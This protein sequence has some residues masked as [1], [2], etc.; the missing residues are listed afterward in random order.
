LR[1]H[2]SQLQARNIVQT[3]LSRV[4]VLASPG[5]G[6]THTL[7]R[8]VQWL[9]SKPVPRT[10]ILVLSFSTAAVRELR[11]RMDAASTNVSPSLATQ[12]SGV[13]IKTIHGYALSL[14]PPAPLL[15]QPA[16]KAMLKK[17]I[18][19][20]AR[21]CRR[22]QLWP[23]LGD[24][25]RVRRSDRILELI[26]PLQLVL[27]GRVLAKARA[28]QISPSEIAHTERA[29]YKL[30]E[31]AINALPHIAAAYRDVKQA[32]NAIDYA[33]MLELATHSIAAQ[34][35]R[36]P[37][38]H[39]LVDEYQDNS[40]AQSAFIAALAKLPHRY[41]MVF[42]DPQQALYGFAGGGYA[43]LAELL[44]GT[45]NM[46]LTL[47]HRLTAQTAALA[48]AI[49]GQAIATNRRGLKPV[50][51]TSADMALQNARVVADIV[52]LLDAGTPA[53]D[54]VVLARSR[55]QLGVVEAALLGS[56][57][58][59]HRQ[60][61]TR[62]KAH[63]LRVL[64]LVSFTSRAKKKDRAV[65]DEDMVRAALGVFADNLSADAK[66]NVALAK[67]KLAVRSHTLEGAYGQC[68]AAYLALLG[69]ARGSGN[70]EALHEVNRWQPMCRDY[71]GAKQMRAA[72]RGM[73]AEWITTSTIHQ[74]KGMQWP[75]VFIVGV[76][77]G[78]LPDHRARHDLATDEER[79][80]LY[81]AITR[82][83]DT[84]RL[85]H[86][87]TA[88]NHSGK[89]HTKLSR[90]LTPAACAHLLSNN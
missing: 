64:R 80:A 76:T 74:A 86:A 5:S 68:A 27:V 32:A 44:P 33:D 53:A 66:W 34:Q 1:S 79:N 77:D 59:T 3:R 38:T 54:I 16:T 8:R 88:H 25:A 60:G 81:V 69:G 31:G 61:S 83:R 35:A 29:A 11:R 30:L 85:Y 87:P 42:G 4:E 72:L 90:F 89:H 21:Q 43:P 51:V 41:L 48:S 52:R 14:I 28:L 15:T 55:A 23:K 22:A 40:P 57:I 78:I 13:A 39:I 58:N 82:A 73:S 70:Q 71:S 75:Y 67:L 10:Q 26:E 7:I 63:A 84:V 37:Y 18:R 62:H 45:V 12:L 47:S 49:A 36:I 9:L 24:A 2:F 20:V 19:R 56:G 65:I 17:A 46:P 50:L 6:K